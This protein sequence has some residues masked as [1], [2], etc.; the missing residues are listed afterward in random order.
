MFNNFWDMFYN[1]PGKEADVYTSQI[2]GVANQYYGK[3]QQMLENPAAFQN[4]QA[5]QFQES[6]GYKYNLEQQLAAANRAAA[7]GGMASSPMHMQHNQEIA[8]GLAAQ[9]YNNWANR[10]MGFMGLGMHGADRMADY[11]AGNLTQKGQYAY[12]RANAHNERLNALLSG[13]SKAFGYMDRNERFNTILS[14]ALKAL[15]FTL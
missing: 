14:N 5:Q 4:Q 15:G 6:P 11:A 2:P 10:N 1:D 7:A 13:A 9:D 3:S 12:N 8:S